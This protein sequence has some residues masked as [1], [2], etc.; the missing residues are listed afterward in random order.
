MLVARFYTVAEVG[1]AAAVISAMNL[2]AALS[3]VG[4]GDAII[5]FLPK[6]EKPRELINSC[7]TV[8]GVLA[9]ALAAVFIAGMGIWSP[10]LVSLRENNASIAAFLFIVLI[11]T[12]SGL[13]DSVFVAGRRAEFVLYK[14]T[15]ASLIK[16]PLAVLLAFSFRGFG[17][18]G[19][20]GI[21]AAVAFIFSLVFL[22]PKVQKHYRFIPA[23]NFGVARNVMSYS[24][25]IYFTSIVDIVSNQFLSIMVA[26]IL[27]SEP[28]A[29]FYMTWMIA[30]LLFAI[31][32][33]ASLSLFAEGAHF[34][35]EMAGKVREALR[36]TL[37]LMVP[38]IIMTLLLAGFLL[39]LFGAAYA[40]NGSLLLRILALSGIFACINSIYGSILRVKNNLKEIQVLVVIKAVVLMAGGYFILPITGIVGIGYVWVA[41]Q[42]I[43]S[44]YV[45]FAMRRLH[46]IK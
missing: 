4:L 16:M 2:L 20:Q 27:G 32:A 23:V 31:P 39:G 15:S 44:V 43:I 35:N 22:V 46:L 42:G 12:A 9:L 40:E 1:A 18:A 21:A 11:F 36:F 45:F 3:L 14:N 8:S 24:A 28:N 7:L 17:I 41:L 33:A 30:N 13:L 37:V 6:A 26:N 34:E 38:A 19:S 5:R 25:G 29:Y 10:A